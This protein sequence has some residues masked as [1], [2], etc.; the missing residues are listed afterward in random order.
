MVGIGHHQL[1]LSIG[2]GDSLLP[3]ECGVVGLEELTLLLIEDSCRIE[4]R[5]GLDFGW[6]HLLSG[7]E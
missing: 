1:A 4:R 2:S 6:A 7:N 5:L 3:S